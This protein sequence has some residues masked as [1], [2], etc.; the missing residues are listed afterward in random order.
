MSCATDATRYVHLKLPTVIFGANGYGAHA[1]DERV[2]LRSLYE[3]AQ[4]FTTYLKSQ[5]R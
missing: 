4:M 2:S 1:S 3:Y 5:I